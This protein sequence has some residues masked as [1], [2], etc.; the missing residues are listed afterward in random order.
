M[1]AASFGQY[2]HQCFPRGVHLNS[3]S[4]ASA[5]VKR[6]TDAQGCSRTLDDAY[7]RIPSPI[8]QEPFQN[9]SE[10]CVLPYLRPTA[11]VERP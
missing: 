1:F 2:Q 9:A 7:H 3:P 5:H 8:V 4:P 11:G 10:P 6:V